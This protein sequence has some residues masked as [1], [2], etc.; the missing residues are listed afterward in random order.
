MS[1][2][3]KSKLATWTTKPPLFGSISSAYKHSSLS[4][5]SIKT[6]PINPKNASLPLLTCGLSPLSMSFSREACASSL[7][8]HSLMKAPMPAAPLKLLVR[9]HAP[10]PLHSLPS[11]TAA[12]DHFLLGQSPLPYLLGVTCPVTSQAPLQVLPALLPGNPGTPQK[13]DCELRFLLLFQRSTYEPRP[14]CKG[15]KIAHSNSPLILQSS[16]T[17]KDSKQPRV[18]LS[19]GILTNTH[20]KPWNFS[21]KVG[22]IITVIIRLSISYFPQV[23]FLKD[24]YK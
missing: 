21:P 19:K 15:I 5:P 11:G 2:F 17:V 7:L 8:C 23:I 16:A 9:R 20:E 12:A 10:P 18:Q 14:I 1:V 22:I 13:K 24:V 6:N 4:Q 3:Q